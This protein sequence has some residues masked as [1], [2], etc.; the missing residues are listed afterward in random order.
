MQTRDE[1][2][3]RSDMSDA[4]DVPGTGACTCWRSC[5]MRHCVEGSHAAPCITSP[6]TRIPCCGSSAGSTAH[7]CPCQQRKTYANEEQSCHKRAGTAPCERTEGEDQ[8]VISPVKTSCSNDAWASAVT[9]TAVVR[10]R[11]IMPRNV[12]SSKQEHHISTFRRSRRRESARRGRGC[13]EGES[14]Y[15]DAHA[16]A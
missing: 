15:Q 2:P 8:T 3:Q 13:H 16:C 5:S 7:V 11:I 14:V 10:T 1:P 9:G 6:W 4:L 12:A